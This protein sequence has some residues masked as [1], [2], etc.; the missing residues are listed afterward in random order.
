MTN[1]YKNKKIITRTLG[2]VFI[3]LYI[4]SFSALVSASEITAENIVQVVNR[5]RQA[6]GITPLAINDQLQAAARNKSIDMIVNNYFDHYALGKTPWMFIRSQNYDYQLAGENLAM[7]Y[8]TSEGIVN[9]WMNSPSHRA[10]ILNPEFQEIGVG[11]V[12]GAYTE[13]GLTSETTITTEML[14]QPK[15]KISQL[16]DKVVSTISNIFK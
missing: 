16:L 15:S 14:A 5:E 10:N 11:V 8:S 4:F 13:N 7:G 2:G 9:A 1:K 12:R 6:N 3:F